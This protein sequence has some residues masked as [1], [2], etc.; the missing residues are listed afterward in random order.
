M[1]PSWPL[2]RYL[3]LAP[4]RW[5]ATRARLNPDELTVQLG[6][7]TVPPADPAS[8]S[9]GPAELDTADSLMA[10]R[11]GTSRTLV[12]DPVVPA[13]S[14]ATVTRGDGDNW[15]LTQPPDQ[16]GTLQLIPD[17]PSRRPGTAW[18]A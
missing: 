10:A 2:D 4:A 3:E 1:L 14:N 9:R 6:S 11:V 15:H 13:A 12:S 5:T 16:Q 18:P 7:V 8:P 17:A